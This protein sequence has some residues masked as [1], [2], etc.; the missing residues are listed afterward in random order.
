MKCCMYVWLFVASKRKS[1]LGERSSM[2]GIHVLSCFSFFLSFFFS[3]QFIVV[4]SFPLLSS[5]F[6]FYI[7]VDFSCQKPNFGTVYQ[8]EKYD[9]NLSKMTTTRRFFVKVN[10]R[11]NLL[12]MHRARYSIFEGGRQREREKSSPCLDRCNE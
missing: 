7:T 8:K 2:N 5:F 1:F 4:H 6:L 12:M 3:V 9:K 11:R 10:D